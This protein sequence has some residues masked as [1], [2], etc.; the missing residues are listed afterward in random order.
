MYLANFN[1]LW[2]T[3]HYSCVCVVFLCAFFLGGGD[4]GFTYMN[5]L[6]PI[7]VLNWKLYH[8][9]LS[10]LQKLTSFIIFSL[11]FKWMRYPCLYIIY[12]YYL[13]ITKH[14][15]STSNFFPYIWWSNIILSSNS[16]I[17]IQRYIC[18]SILPRIKT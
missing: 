12:M 16:T 5:K 13:T 2:R 10:F 15:L 4:L 6:C 1:E 14:N 18:D 11:Y 8:L 17:Y 7:L 3:E 9:L